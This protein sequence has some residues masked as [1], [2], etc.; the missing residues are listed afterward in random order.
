LLRD[1]FDYSV[2]ETADALGLKE[3][4][5]KTTHHRARRKMAGYD[6]R[7]FGSP[8]TRAPEVERALRALMAALASGDVPTV[9]ALLSRDVRAV[10]DAGGEFLA[11]LR[12]VS[13]ANK[14]AR[15]FTALSARAGPA[16]V[17]SRRLNGL[18]ALLIEMEQP[19]PRTGAR[20][21]LLADVDPA[22]KLRE[23]SVVIASAKLRR[24]FASEPPGAP[25][26]L[27]PLGR[28]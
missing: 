2:R 10:T 17:V 18:P 7:R 24:L 6:E 19:R 5:V 3:G 27:A 9:E 20:M 1:V 23:I 26:A 15:L 21:A 14:V 8:S 12:P 11:A 13:G 4:A 22:G 16:G 28:A 25:R